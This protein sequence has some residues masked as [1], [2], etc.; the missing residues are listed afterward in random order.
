MSGKEYPDSKEFMG[1][2]LSEY[3]FI[4]KF[5]VEDRYYKRISA[6]AKL[7][8]ALFIQLALEA[9]RNGQQDSYGN[10]YITIT[11]KEIREFLNCSAHK[12]QDVLKELDCRHGVGLICKSGLGRGYKTNIYVN[13]YEKNE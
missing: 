1:N 9:E 13:L 5:I 12:A 3:I 11:I 2:E 10:A 7:L 8:Y 4:P 6:E